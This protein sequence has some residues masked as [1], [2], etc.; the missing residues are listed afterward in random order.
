MH[1]GS[2]KE[3]ADVLTDCTK[4]RIENIFLNKNMNVFFFYSKIDGDCDNAVDFI[5]AVANCLMYIWNAFIQ[6]LWGIFKHGVKVFEQSTLDFQLKHTKAQH[7]G[8]WCLLVQY[9]LGKCSVWTTFGKQI[10]LGI[11]KYEQSA[12]EI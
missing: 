3:F 1:L 8:I 11:S 10:L 5:R 2:L 12:L 7:T 9:F 4:I 6:F